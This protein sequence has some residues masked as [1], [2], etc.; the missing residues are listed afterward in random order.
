MT[1]NQQSSDPAFWAGLFDFSFT[2]FITLKF[3]R[4]I[5]IVL[6]AVIGLIGL[7][8]FIVSLTR[9]G[10]GGVFVGLIVVP[11]VTLFYIIGARLT[12][13]VIAVIFRIGENTS[14]IAE[15]VGVMQ[16]RPPAAGSG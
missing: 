3:I 15:S 7:V 14:R 4:V 2:R 9:G 1:S 10:A 6:V 16:A 11:L 8:L 5:Y 12:L 13:E